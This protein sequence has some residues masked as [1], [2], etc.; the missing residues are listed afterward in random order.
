MIPSHLHNLHHSSFYTY[1]PSMV[2]QVTSLLSMV[3]N[4][5]PTFS[6][7]SELH[8][9]WR[10][11]SLPDIIPKVMDKLNKIIRLWNSTSE[12]FATTNKTIG[13]NSF[14]YLSSLTTILRVPLPALHPYLPTRVTTWTLPF[15]Q[16]TTLHL[17][18]LMTLSQILMSYTNSS[19][20]TF[21][22][23]N[24]NTKFP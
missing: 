23:H 18:A 1:S 4:L 3:Q 21:P 8:W 20:S 6:V 2:S 14:H 12:S 11:T 10:F 17:H 16:S 24:V 13:P 9:T 7:P 15:I 22:K 5:Y 19:G